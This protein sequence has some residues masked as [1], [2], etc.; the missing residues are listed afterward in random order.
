M[1]EICIVGDAR[2]AI[3]GIGHAGCANRVTQVTGLGSIVGE[4]ACRARSFTGVVS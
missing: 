1:V 3:S 4:V 2:K